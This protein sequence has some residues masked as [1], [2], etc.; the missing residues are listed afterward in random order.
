MRIH[1]FSGGRAALVLGALAVSG[2]ADILYVANEANNTIERISSTGSDLGTFAQNPSF[3]AAAFGLAFDTTAD[4]FVAYGN[5]FKAL[6]SFSPNGTLDFSFAPGLGYA[7][8]LA[9]D[10][11]GNLYAGSATQNLIEKFSTNGTDLGTFATNGLNAPRGIAF[12][13]AGNL[14]AANSGNNTIEKFSQDGT[15]LGAFASSATAPLSWP[16]GLAFDGAGNL[17]VA[18]LLANS[19][20]KLSPTGTDLG[21]FASKGLNGP[22]GLAFDSAGNL[23]VANQGSSSIAKFTPAGAGSV[24]ATNGIHGPTFLAFTDDSGKPLPL[25]P[26]LAPRIDV[27]P[28]FTPGQF[29]VRVTGIRGTYVVQAT[30]VLKS[31]TNS[32][33][34]LFTSNSVSGA[35]EFLDLQAT[36]PARFYRAVSQ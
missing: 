3:G 34:S 33:I 16:H 10:R 24:F 7:E 22:E 27:V 30:A 19:V 28:P 14:Y 15:D 21:T 8:G 4:L 6:A 35:F 36:N 12:D 1:C 5:L 13:S 23:Y 29:R 11:A 25:P 2:H 20:E 26:A 18:N 32:W 9:F 31:P 17:Y